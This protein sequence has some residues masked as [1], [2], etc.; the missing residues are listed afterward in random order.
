MKPISESANLG[1][2]D[3]ALFMG[4]F[5]CLS[6][7]GVRRR[8]V[9]VPSRTVRYGP[10]TSFV[11]GN[12][13]VCGCGPAVPIMGLARTHEGVSLPDT[14]MTATQFWQIGQ[15]L[16]GIFLL[17]TGLSSAASTISIFGMEFEPRDSRVWVFIATGLQ[18]AVWVAAG[19]LLMRRPLELGG[20]HTTDA[21][22]PEWGVSAVPPA[23]Q[24]L[25]LYFLVLGL[26]SAATLALG[27]FWDGKPWL[28]LGGETG[29]ALIMLCAG[30]TLMTRPSLIAEKLSQWRSPQQRAVSRE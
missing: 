14:S 25:G 9:T 13:A 22:S 12:V 27:L 11:G 29:T 2:F 10:S 7:R 23:L 20:G 4:N 21:S 18:A 1:N 24:L 30:V 28:M 19:A 15:R 6:M 16:L 8:D 26:Q 5:N 17:V 3:A